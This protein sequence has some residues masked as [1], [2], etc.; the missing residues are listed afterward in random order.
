MTYTVYG[1]DECI[2]TIDGEN[3][4][5]AIENNFDSIVRF[6]GWSEIDGP[7]HRVYMEWNRLACHSK[8]GIVLYIESNHKYTVEISADSFEC[9]QQVDI[10]SVCAAG[11]DPLGD[12]SSMTFDALYGNIRATI[13]Y[14]GQN[15]CTVENSK[16]IMEHLAAQ[17]SNVDI[18]SPKVYVGLARK[19]L[20][21]RKRRESSKELLY[22][23]RVLI[24]EFIPMEEPE[25]QR[26]TM[27]YYYKTQQALYRTYQPSPIA[28]YRRV[29]NMTQRQ[30]ADA[31][32][33]SARRI[34]Q[35]ENGEVS[36]LDC[37]YEFVEKIAD[38]LGVT[39]EMVVHGTNN[40]KGRQ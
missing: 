32:G 3:L 27:L 1:L 13:D 4:I 10:D 26:S 40:R 33:V 38:A 22:R 14:V 8:G 28:Y 35:F 5:D 11:F 36:L 17:S 39:T 9:P 19:E 21:N 16:S 29:V 25:S 24:A 20:Y 12:S 18:N 15:L 34:R 7:F 37:K 30:L 31:V 6:S 2:T 23:I